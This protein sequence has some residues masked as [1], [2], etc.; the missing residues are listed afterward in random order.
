MDAIV[1]ARQLLLFLHLL[2]FAVALSTVVQADL[3]ILRGRLAEAGLPASARS[4]ALWLLGL[5][6]TG[7]ALIGLDT[8]FDPAVLA[9][10]PKLL[11]KLT[12]V[13]LLSLNGL[14]LH[15]LAFPVLQAVGTG[16]S[17]NGLRTC[18]LLG[19]VSTVS[20]L[21]ASFVGSARFIA[22]WM[23][24]PAYM[25]LYALALGLGLAVS[26]TWVLPRLRRM[27]AGA[28]KPSVAAP[29]TAAPAGPEVATAAPAP[30]ANLIAS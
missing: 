27:L 25:L 1:L 2:M 7:L 13:G 4:L 20:W 19:A 12:V 14:A 16:A 23:N 26:V 11:A 15:C 9:G 29:A 24:Y 8:G 17:A 10:K 28:V 30:T 5:W 18:A 3:A 21:F 22:P 6:L